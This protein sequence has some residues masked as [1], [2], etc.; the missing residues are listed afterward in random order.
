MSAPGGAARVVVVCGL[1][2]AVTA[3]TIGTAFFGVHTWLTWAPLGGGLAAALLGALAGLRRSGRAAVHVALSRSRARLVA[4]CAL[5]VSLAVVANAAALQAPVIVDVTASK[6]NTLAEASVQ[7]ARVLQRPV[8]ITAVLDG[9]DRAWVELSDLVARYQ[10]ETPHITLE[11]VSPDAD[12]TAAA[13]EAKVLVTA[14][15]ASGNESGEEGERRQRVRF[16]AG[17]PDQEELLTKAL[18]AVS[19]DRRPRAYFLAGHEEPALADD[20]PA[21]LRRFG[22]A[23][24]DD[25]LEVVPLPLPVV[26]QIPEDASLV[27]VV[28]SRAIPAAEAALLHE[29]LDEGGRL[30]VLLEPF[31]DAGLASLLGSVGIQADDDVVVDRSTFSGLVGGPETATGVAYASHPVTQKLGGA[32]THFSRARSLS[33]NP[34]TPAEPQP[35]VQTGAEA[36][37]EMTRGPASFDDADV[38]GPVTLALAA[39]LPPVAGRAPGRIVVFGDATFATNQGLGLGANQDLLLNASQWL[40]GRDDGI[41]VRPRGRGGNLLLLSPTSRERI[42]F[43]LL[44]GL[45]VALLCAGLSVSAIR[46]RR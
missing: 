32:M 20:A 7:V 8:K 45:P 19:L 25:G 29:H 42:A 41:V 21:G 10:R 14:P 9:A 11:R 37:G 28:A 27:I 33:M 23:L 22:Q 15:P 12:P 35:L 46:R 18:R 36:F 4:E 44:Y 3:A 2:V 39:E 1:A 17:A 31:E 34:G 40:V 30:L 16:T 13:Y 6:K 38:G 5:V 26:K 43:V 24:V